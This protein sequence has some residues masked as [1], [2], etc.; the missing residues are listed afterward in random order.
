[1]DVVSIGET[2]VLFASKEDGQLR[3]ASNFSARVAGAETNTLI[4]LAKLGHKTGWISRVGADELGAKIIQSVRGEGVDTT[5]VAM[6]EQAPTGLFLKEQTTVKTANILYY[7]KGSAASR[8]EPADINEDYVK[9]AKFL[10]L[11]GITPLLSKS[12]EQTTFVFIEMAKKHHVKI[13]FDPNIRKKLLTEEKQKHL[14]ERLIGTADI[15]LPGYGEGHYLFGT[16]NSEE[17][18]DRCLQL[19][20]QLTVVKL[21]EKGAYYKSTDQSG[22]VAPIP[23]KEV[24]DP[25]GAGDGFAAGVLSGL[26]DGL[27]IKEAVGR[28]CAIGAFVTQVHGDIEGLPSRQTLHA[29]QQN[30]EDVNR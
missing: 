29:F 25:I 26:L 3:Y 20:A 11:T 22:Y 16:N 6:D 15:V 19:G 14:L 12:C 13:V 28:G 30:R 17:I 21:G 23:V 24:V 18:A 2:M 5:Y 9:N 1:M 27:A 8:L 10:Y 7:R 4:G